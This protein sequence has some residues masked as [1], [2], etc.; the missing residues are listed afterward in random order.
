MKKKVAIVIPTFRKNLLDFEI[1]S[2]AQVIKVLKD[3]DKFFALPFSLEYSYTS[4]EIKEIRLDD[5]Y[6]ESIFSYN[7]LMMSECFYQLF[8][9]YEYI[10]IYLLDAFVFFDGLERFCS[11]NYDYIGAP[12][13]EGSFYYKDSK[14]TIWYVGNGGLSLRR[15]DSF[16]SVLRRNQELLIN[17]CINEDLFF[18][19][20][21]DQTFHIAPESIALEFSFEMK[22]KECYE[23]NKK[24]L[25]FGCHAWQ[26]F[27][28]PFWRR[29]IENNGYKISDRMLK[30]GRKD[31]DHS[32]DVKKKLIADF[33]LNKYSKG[34]FKKQIERL[35]VGEEGEY[36]IWGAGYWGQILCR[37]MVDAGLSVCFFVDSQ[38]ELVQCRILGYN[39]VLPEY[40]KRNVVRYR[41]II[42]IKNGYNG[43]MKYLKSINYLHYEGF[44]CLHDIKILYDN[45]LM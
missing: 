28:L 35:F 14:H 38:E 36:V 43:V 40:L 39:I 11:M 1:I 42:A 9:D 32:M 4:R 17:N 25:P 7:K 22:V 31:D 8:V 15:V 29:W 23:K 2:L 13:I 24:H 44:I 3:Y 27:D 19:V 21:E 41:I 6:F 20:L 34:M 12:W 10:L 30:E 37:M 18:S 33:W 5:K 45:V 26:R 16:I